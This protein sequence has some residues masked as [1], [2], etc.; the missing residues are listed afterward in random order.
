M[1]TDWGVVTLQA[2]QGA[3]Q[4]FLGFIPALIGAIII[5]IIGWFISLGVG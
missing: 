5:F 2:L 3:W 4:G 1:I